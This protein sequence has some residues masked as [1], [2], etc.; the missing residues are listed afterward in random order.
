MCGRV[1]QLSV[2]KQL[3]QQCT[4]KLYSVKASDN[5]RRM[6]LREQSSV[7]AV[8]TA[9]EVGDADKV[10]LKRTARLLTNAAGGR[11]ATAPRRQRLR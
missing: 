1:T 7:N 9:N 11:Y 2:E 3:L 8:P 10:L 4:S 5:Q 6:L